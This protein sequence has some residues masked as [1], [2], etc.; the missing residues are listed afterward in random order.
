M[1]EAVLDGGA[2]NARSK[3][4]LRFARR[5]PECGADFTGRQPAQL[6]CSV[7]HK[8]TYNNRWMKRGA[9]LAP[10]YA[11]AR[12]TRNG[13]RGDAAT[14]KRASSDANHLIQRW[15]DEDAAQGRMSAV[16]YVAARY[17]LG[18]VEVA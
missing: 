13:T 6:F 5:C 12:A 7:E 16:D 17:R 3:A 14:G 1:T 8:R 10:L 9:V 4:P 18:L 11:A 15:K 2:P